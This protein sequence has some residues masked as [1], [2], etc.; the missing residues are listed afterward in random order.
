MA[1]ITPAATFPVYSGSYADT[2][3][4]FSGTF[5]P[6]LWSGK[7]LETLYATTTFGAC[8]NTNYEG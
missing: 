6:T 5:I 7:M 3:P 4:P 2:T 8:S 1:N